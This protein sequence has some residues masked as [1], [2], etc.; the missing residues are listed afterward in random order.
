[1]VRRGHGA[2]YH[3]QFK[4]TLDVC[5]TPKLA[6]C[7]KFYT[8][9]QNGLIQDWGREICWMNPPY[10]NGL[11]QWVR[12]AWKSAQ[13]GAVV[14]CLLPVFTDAAWFHDFASHATI[15]L[16]RGRLQFGNREHNGYTP[17]SHGIYIF[18]QKSARHGAKL[19][20]SLDPH[21]IGTSSPK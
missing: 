1:M 2:H 8:P 21:R 3:R 6:K 17:F 4:F 5:A 19:T 13:K 15:E 10:G 14:V 7:K 16:L 12:K 11:E 18:R 20:I 9:A